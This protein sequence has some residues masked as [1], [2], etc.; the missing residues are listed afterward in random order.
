MASDV[1]MEQGRFA[2]V[3]PE[4]AVFHSSRHSRAGGNPGKSVTELDPRLRGDDG[5]GTVYEFPD[6]H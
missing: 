1:E 4:T 3:H 5:L 2:S 6:G